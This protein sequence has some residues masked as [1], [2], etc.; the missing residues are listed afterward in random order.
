MYLTYPKRLALLVVVDTLIVAFSIFASAYLTYNQLVD[1]KSIVA[2]SIILLLSHHILALYF[3]LYRK[4]WE[5]ASIGELVTIFNVVGLSIGVA[6]IGQLVV[7]DQIMVRALLATFML[8]ILFIGG[9][10]FA[11]RV[12][13]DR[14]L[15]RMTGKKRTLI[16]GAGAGGVMVARQLA[17]SQESELRPVAFVDDDPK[18]SRVQIL[19]VPVAGKLDDIERIVEQYRIEH[20]IFA[21]PSIPKA[22]ANEIYQLCSKTGVKTQTIPKFEDL[23]TGKVSVTELR[24]VDIEDLLGREPVKL[25]MQKIG[26]NIRNKTV[27]I[28]GA[29]GSIGSEI[30]RQIARF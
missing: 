21:I 3:G 23:V 16:I 17:S 25:D 26:V 9:S 20:I 27:L 12:F 5:Y 13:R 24:D 18:K 11:W 10:R 30:C 7:L 22:R 14:V 1:W 29:G 4:A 2:T 6:A 28:T 15:S 19:N 8:H